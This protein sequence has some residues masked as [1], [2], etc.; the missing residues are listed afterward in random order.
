MKELEDFE[1]FPKILRQYQ[2]DFIGFVV[3]Q[4][5]VYSP[6][7]S[8]LKNDKPQNKH[9]FDLCSGSGEPAISIFKTIDYFKSLTLSDKFPSTSKTLIA[10]MAY[11]PEPMDVLIQSFQ[12]SYTYTMF[13]ALHHFNDKQQQLIVLNMKA[14][15]AEAYFVE[16]LAPHF[17]FYLKILFTT[18]IGTLLFTPFIKPFSLKRL[19]FT[20]CIPIN[21]ITITYDG[22]LSVYKSKSVR[23]YQKLFTGLIA[24]TEIFE[25][26][27]GLFSLIVIKIKS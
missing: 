18:T 8:Q 17:L 25:L 22:L 21:I 20:Y 5:K 3:S 12:P 19:F 13:N 4:F 26:K 23:Q 14:Q 27:K 2:T 7:I 10:P 15:K 9:M 24:P 1:W 6:F 16:I 11:I